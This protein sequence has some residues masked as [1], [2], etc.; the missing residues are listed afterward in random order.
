MWEYEVFNNDPYID[1]ASSGFTELDIRIPNDA[2]VWDTM[3]VSFQFTSEK[4]S[5]LSYM[6]NFSIDV[7][8]RADVLITTDS[9]LI[10]EIPGIS[11]EQKLVI[12]NVG[13]GND[14]FTFTSQIGEVYKD[15]QL[16][17][18]HAEQTL[19]LLPGESY[20]INISYV[21]GDY[22]LSLIHI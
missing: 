18:S 13:N 5:N 19:I 7:L 1:Y 4:D 17:I 21:F 20:D 11:G 14:T 9:Q 22:N 3:A 10:S 2:L 6:F 8:Q 15:S 12:T 16:E